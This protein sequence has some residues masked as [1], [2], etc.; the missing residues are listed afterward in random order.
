MPLN[1]AAKGSQQRLAVVNFGNPL[2][3][4]DIK[5]LKGNGHLIFYQ[6]RLIKTTINERPI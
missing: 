1:Y 2:K 6:V 3:A 5:R 4:T